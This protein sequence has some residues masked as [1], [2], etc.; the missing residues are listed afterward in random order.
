[1]IFNKFI[2]IKEYPGS[3]P[4][5]TLALIE[6]KEAKLQYEGTV[7]GTLSSKMIKSNQDYWKPIH[8]FTIGDKVLVDNVVRIVKEAKPTSIKAGDIWYD[9][10]EFDFYGIRAASELELS[11]ELESYMPTA[12]IWKAVKLVLP[13]VYWK[14]VLIS[15][16]KAYNG[17]WKPDWTNYDQP[18]YAIT[19][20]EITEVY[21]NYGIPVF[22]TSNLAFRAA[23]LL[24]GYKHYLFTDE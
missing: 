8:T 3:A 14:L 2:L 17:A 23:N 19:E 20:N 16:A 13:S 4:K 1:M 18:K 12:G 24:N 22:K 5:G 15:I 9:T 6:Q 10:T 21:A 7:L 11:N